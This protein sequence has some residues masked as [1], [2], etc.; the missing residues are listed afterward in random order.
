MK[1]DLISQ[2]Q[3]SVYGTIRNDKNPKRATLVGNMKNTKSL[4]KRSHVEMYVYIFMTVSVWWWALEILSAQR[5]GVLLQYWVLFFPLG[6]SHSHCIHIGLSQPLLKSSS[7]R[8]YWNL[9]WL[10]LQDKCK[11]HS[12]IFIIY[13]DATAHFLCRKYLLPAHKQP[14][15]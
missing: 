1:N 13:Q 12:L 2:G 5:P 6:S 11:S 7:S 8:I 4:W 14:W 15:I 9:Y 10:P 3:W